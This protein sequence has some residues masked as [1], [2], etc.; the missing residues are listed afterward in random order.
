MRILVC[1]YACEPSSGSEPGAGWAWSRAM[2]RTH[3]VTVLTRVN[4]RSAIEAASVDD[5]EGF[6][7]K[8][9]YIDLPRAVRA[10]KSRGLPIQLYYVLWQF[11]AWRHARRLVAQARFDLVH[12]LTFA[13][14]WMPAAVLWT[15][16]PVKVWGPVGGEGR[17]AL[18][19]VRWTGFRGVCGEV[20]RRTIVAA[21]RRL[22]APRQA[23]RCDL[24]I[25]QNDD[26]RRRLESFALV[27]TMP[28]AV[29]PSE[30]VHGPVRS[31][32]D[33]RHFTA[34]YV[35]RLAGWKGVQL[36]IAAL[37]EPE[38]AVWR[39]AIYGAGPDQARLAR[40]ARRLGVADRVVFHGWQ[41][42]S[43]VV[44]AMRTCQAV[45]VPSL[46]D[47]APFV[48]AEAEAVGAP[49]IAFDLPHIA[50]LVRSTVSTL[51]PLDGRP[52]SALARGLAQVPIA[53]DRRTEWLEDQLQTRVAMLFDTIV[54]ASGTSR[55]SD[56]CDVR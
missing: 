40:A 24:V 11:A 31:S 19:N 4:N 33:I 49:V 37:A 45:I 3:D 17:I 54:G 5:P 50:S 39:L 10:A 16:V 56:E 12:H 20:T 34:V 36:A 41:P 21:I 1:A 51:V 27:R 44:E 28:N 38:A 13:T 53:V 47:A 9:I 42:R 30:L 15:D 2:A 29:V 52:A 32:A 26:V 48:I 46:R 25:A 35:G 8:Y 14:D 7:P 23:R 6:G 43:A 55:T 18:R 22:V